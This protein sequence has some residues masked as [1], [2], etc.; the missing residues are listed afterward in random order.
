MSSV[1]KYF[2]FNTYIACGI[3][4]VELLGTEQDW[5][6]LIKKLEDVKKV[7]APISQPLGNI[8][9]YFD[10]IVLP[11]YQNLLE[12]FLGRPNKT[13]WN[14]IVLR[15]AKVEQVC[16]SAA[17]YP[18]RFLQRCLIPGLHQAEEGGG[19]VG[20]VA[21]GVSQWGEISGAP[22]H[23]LGSADS[24]AKGESQQLTGT[25]NRITFE[26]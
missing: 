8:T 23:C 26:G 15:Q 12:T 5:R 13:W 2:N 17:L 19:A 1:Q 22:G 16:C 7:L 4:E 18:S 24:S 14:D 9:T 10:E 21:G 6:D 3:P 25:G 20:R 11:V